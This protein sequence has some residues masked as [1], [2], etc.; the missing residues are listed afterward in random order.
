MPQEDSPR[1]LPYRPCVGL[2][3]L[4]GA[5]EIFAGRRI[6]G[7]EDA[8]QMPQGGV[9]DGEELFAAA[10]RELGEETGLAP[11]HVTLLAETRDWV[12][13]DLPPELKG[14]IW[15]GRFGGQRQKWFALRLIAPDSAIDIATEEP[16]FNAWRWMDPAGLLAAVVPFKRHVYE[17]V[18]AEF[19][20]LIA[21]ADRA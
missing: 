14:R 11:E 9:D 13:Y 21:P 5:G 12:L 16:E 7:A 19:A 20:P 8:W 15:G 18:L 10:L 3:L 1:D 4:N 17:A 6:D 2:M